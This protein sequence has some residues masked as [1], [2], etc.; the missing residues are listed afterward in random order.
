M[1]LKAITQPTPEPKS[2]IRDPQ[3]SVGV[4]NVALTVLTVLATILVL[5]YAQETIIP[6]VLG[7]LISY[8]LEP[9]VAALTRWHL[10]RP[11]A[12]AIVLVGIPR[13]RAAGCWTGLQRRRAPSCISCRMGPGVCAG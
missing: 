11:L 10:P 2:A 4:R 1:T 7:V 6:I 13:P 9:F 3:P 8:A 12:A 5:K